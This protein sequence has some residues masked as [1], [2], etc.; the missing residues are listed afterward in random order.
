MSS[1]TVY[2]S[3]L[4]LPL[5]A[6]GKVRDIYEV[7][8]GILLVASDR[9]S[10]FDV[11][12]GDPIPMKGAVLNRLAAYWFGQT[13][14]LVANH[15]IS[16]DSAAIPAVA[17]DPAMR[18]RCSLCRR[19][20]PFPVE[21]VV[22]GYLEGSAWKDYQETGM[23]SGVKL[24]EGLRRRERL[25]EPVFTPSTKA[26]E[27]HDEPIDFARVVELVGLNAA[28]QL[29]ALSIELFKFA[30]AKLL[31]MGIVLSD[32]KFEFGTAEDGSI[33]LIDEVLTP[34]SS[35]FWE[36]ET[37]W[38]D[39]VPRSFDKQYVRDYVESIGWDKKPPAPKLPDEVIDGMTQRYVE[40][41]NLITGGSLG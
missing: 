31:P 16:A 18:N 37:Y 22:R 21:C 24:P 39:S 3:Q 4:D 30:H 25:V 7:P 38:P 23:V 13:E 40:I 14:H 35:R 20:T 27:G 32:T 33:I 17:G 2:E 29:R 11:V 12:F 6:R 28:S 41:Y 36:A 19:A 34:D 26:E 5:I 1:Q 10:A 8:E 9:L 15:L